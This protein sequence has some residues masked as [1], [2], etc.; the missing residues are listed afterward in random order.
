MNIPMT[1]DA[2]QQWTRTTAA[3]PKSRAL[4][5]TLGKLSS[6]AGEPAEHFFKLLRKAQEPLPYNEVAMLGG[7]DYGIILHEL[8]DVLWYV[9]R[10]ADELGLTMSDVMAAN[11]EKLERRKREGTITAVKRDEE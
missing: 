2:Y 10:A 5:Y 3:Y 4:S 7:V 6:E 8:G 1:I 11:V 9:A